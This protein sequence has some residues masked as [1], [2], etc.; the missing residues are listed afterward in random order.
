M[1]LK[2]QL[3]LVGFV[4]LESDL[5]DAVADAAEQS[6][7]SGARQSWGT[8]SSRQVSLDLQ[9][10]HKTRIGLQVWVGGNSVDEPVQ[11]ELVTLYSLQQNALVSVSFYGFIKQ[12]QQCIT[13]AWSKRSLQSAYVIRHDANRLYRNTKE[14]RH[15]PLNGGGGSLWS[16]PRP[17]KENCRRHNGRCLHSLA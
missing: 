17:I 14:C 11:Q 2:H 4:N 8:G 3:Y 10:V 9:E 13:F 7:Y 15:R 5:P 16:L 6:H 1:V 12:L